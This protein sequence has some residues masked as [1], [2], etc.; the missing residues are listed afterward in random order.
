MEF[1]EYQPPCQKMS[2]LLWHAQ[3]MLPLLSSQKGLCILQELI[4]GPPPNAGGPAFQKSW[5]LL[6][7]PFLCLFGLA[8]W[9]T[10]FCHC[11]CAETDTAL[12]AQ[13][14]GPCCQELG[15]LK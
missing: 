7:N 10:T 3:L 15:Q 1:E 6:G 2:L 14:G 4:R 11:F 12:P 13:T 9:Q 5:F 8:R